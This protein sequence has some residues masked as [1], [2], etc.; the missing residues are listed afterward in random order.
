MSITRKATMK[1]ACI[2]ENPAGTYVAPNVLLPFTSQDANQ[3]WESIPDNSVVGV[4]F[5]NL[6]VQGVRA[7]RGPIEIQADLNTLPV[8]LLAA[9]GAVG[10]GVYSLPTT[11][12]A[13][14]LSF[15]LLNGVKTNKYAGCFL[16]NFNFKSSAK[17]DAKITADI[18]GYK[19]EGRDDTAFPTTSISEG[20][21]ILHQQADSV[22]GSGYVRI[23]DQGNA[24]AAGDNVAVKEI[25]FGINWGFDTD[26]YNS[27]E[28]LIPLSGAAGVPEASFKL[29]LNRHDTDQY[30]AWRDAHTHLQAE[31]KYYVS[32]TKSLL[33]QVPN[34]I[35]RPKLSGDEIPSVDL[36]IIVGR[37]GIGTDYSNAN[38]AFVTPIRVTHANA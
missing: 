18:L 35:L 10:T 15:C 33:I 23:G 17:E 31:I 13:E 4:A 6:P 16:N 22:N 8:M 37:N 36:D 20:S 29:V 2:R 21:R 24:L 7:V 12:N 38:M 28:S 5:K 14:A 30:H 26:H 9:F 1:M 3:E 34:F 32:A 11:A 27:M 19:A 25:G